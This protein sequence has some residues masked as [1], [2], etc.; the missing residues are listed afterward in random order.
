VNCT[1]IPTDL[2]EVELFGSEKGAYTDAH[3]RKPGLVEQAHRGTLFLDEIGHVPLPLQPKLLNVIEERKVRRIGSRED[4]EVDVRVVAATNR[5]LEKA[6]ETGKFRA[7]L[8]YRLNV[9]PITVPPLRDRE[10]DVLLLAHHFPQLFAGE[11]GKTIRALSPEAE[12]ALRRHPWPGNVRELKN[13]VERAVLL[14]DSEVLQASDFALSLPGAG[15]SATS[16]SSEEKIDWEDTTLEEVEKTHILRVLERTRGNRA[17]AARIGGVST[18]TL[19]RKLKE[20][21]QE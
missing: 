16:V 4:V 7:D 10:V 20:W 1:A 18:E 14:A 11:F 9:I 13:A 3:D 19:R 15:V 17:H 12:E 21:K 8:F 6:I 5:N 2:V